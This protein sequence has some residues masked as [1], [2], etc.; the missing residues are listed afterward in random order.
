M[1]KKL[2]IA[3]SFMSLTL[4]ASIAYSMSSDPYNT[5]GTFGAESPVRISANTQIIPLM[6]AFSEMLDQVI[7]GTRTSPIDNRAGA[8]YGARY[9]S[10]EALPFPEGGF[11]SQYKPRVVIPQD[12]FASSALG[13]SDWRQV[14]NTTPYITPFTAMLDIPVDNTT[15]RAGVRYGGLT[16]EQVLALN[17]TQAEKER[18]RAILAAQISSIAKDPNYVGVVDSG[19]SRAGVRYGMIMPQESFLPFNWGGAN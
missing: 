2:K 9:G 5:M 13:L 6:Q 11:N 1:K 18:R 12:P 14:R 8:R 17:Q 15:D 7:A 3:V 19:L 4:S 10:F 16:A